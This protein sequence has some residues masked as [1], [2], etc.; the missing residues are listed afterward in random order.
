MTFGDFD[1]LVALAKDNR[2]SD[3]HV[4]VGQVP[5]FRIDGS[6]VPVGE[7]RYSMKEM[8]GV[9]AKVVEDSHSMEIL[10]STG[11]LDLPYSLAGVGRLRVNVY[12]QRGSYALAARLLNP[13][14]PDPRELSIPDSVVRCCDK[15][16]GMILFTGPTGSGKSTSLASLIDYVNRR[17]NYHIITLED[18]VEYLHHHQRSIVHQREIGSDSLSYA[19]A[20][21]GALRE[22]PDVILI[23]EMRDLETISIA[24]TA[25]ETGHLVFSTL[26]TVSAV[27]TVNRIIDVFPPHQ[28]Q[29]IRTQLADILE[30]VVAE[31]LLPRIEG[32]GRVAAYEVMLANNAIRNY[33]REGKTFQI[34]STIQTS[35]SS[36][37]ITMDDYI[38]LLYQNGEI[39]R[40][41]ALQFS[42]D[43]ISQKNRLM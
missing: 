28:Q 14:I 34:T 29:Q 3:I 19:N 16:R 32:T 42:R 27:D 31:Q 9:L 26:H 25:A 5:S 18:P 33:I 7:Q 13:T 4:S 11:E 22:D 17:Y 39:D 12:R 23:G 21:R 15:K 20:L 41:T 2:A 30:C 43:K 37:M 8:D 24:A 36:G 10:R 6:I 40:D 35:R 1:E 38:Q